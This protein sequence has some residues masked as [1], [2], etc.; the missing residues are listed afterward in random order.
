MI[1]SKPNGTCRST[2]DATWLALEASG[3][4]AEDAIEALAELVAARFHEANNGEDV[5]SVP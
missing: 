3:H 2:L 4:D 5:A 1:G